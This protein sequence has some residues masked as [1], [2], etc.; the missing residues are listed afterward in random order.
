MDKFKT[1]ALRNDSEEWRRLCYTREREGR[2]TK[3]LLMGGLRK[4]ENLLLK[5]KK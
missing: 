1:G 3:G 4:M 2:D 5:G